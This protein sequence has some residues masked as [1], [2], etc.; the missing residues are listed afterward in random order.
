M[1][2]F[3]TNALNWLVGI[4][5]ERFGL[6]FQLSFE[7]T[8]LRLELMGA[9]QGYILFPKLEKVFHQS[10]SDLPCTHWNVDK[11]D[12]VSVLGQ[13]LPAPGV[14][15]LSSPLIEVMPDYHVIHYDVLG[16]TYWM[17]NRVE[18]V[19]RTDLD[20]H[21]RF[22]AV[23]SHA[24]QHNYLERPIVD[25]WLHILG[26]VIQ[27]QWP[28][29]SLKQHQFSMKVSHDVDSPSRYRFVS[30]K[31]LI[32]CMAGDL[33]KRQDVKGAMSAPL[34]RLSS[35]D[36]L[37]RA[38]SF[39]TFDWIMDR[40]DKYNLI[41]AF[42]FIC[43]RTDPKKDADYEIEH[44][45]IRNLMRC[46]HERG[47]EIGL[48]PS[49]NSFQ[50]PDIIKQEADRLRIVMREENIQ[51]SVFGGRMHYL[52]W[53]HPTT[54]QAWNDAGMTYDSTLSYADRPGFR[55]GTCFEFPAFNS[56]TQQVLKIRIRPLIVMEST[57]IAERYMGLGYGDS[58]YEKFKKLKEY[59]RLVNGCFTLLWHNSHLVNQ[60]DFKMYEKV[61]LS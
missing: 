37:A 43:G 30:T 20:H 5:H 26:Q 17:L 12:W 61:I 11:S 21:G 53:E 56:V 2:S 48:H 25:E 28:E 9:E 7:G 44:P 38:D 16:L 57:V 4:L 58:A 29:V 36:Y 3:S 60:V 46:M 34:I 45:I 35:K 59:C 33:I 50:S 51:Q 23:H 8:S 10:R 6:H 32:K 22:P 39:N 47:H 18:E 49:Y 42:Y 31:K 15:V 1:V 41:S 27:R 55:C 13:P 19:G 52:R 54:L 24:Y 14:D 40:S